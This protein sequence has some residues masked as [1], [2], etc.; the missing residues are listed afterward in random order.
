MQNPYLRLL[1]SYSVLLIVVGN[2]ICVHYSMPDDVLAISG[3]FYLKKLGQYSPSRGRQL[4]V[5]RKR[6]G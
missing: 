1:L 5:V 6:N 2:T 4:Q 3:L